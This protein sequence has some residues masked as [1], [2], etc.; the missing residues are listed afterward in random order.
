MI[1]ILDLYNVMY[2]LWF[3]KVPKMYKKNNGKNSKIYSHRYF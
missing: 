3:C 2:K 1:F